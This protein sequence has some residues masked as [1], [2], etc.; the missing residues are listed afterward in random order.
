MEKIY[1]YSPIGFRNLFPNINIVNTDFTQPSRITFNF[2]KDTLRNNT[3]NIVFMN[4]HPE[5]IEYFAKHIL[6][7][8]T[9][10][11]IIIAA[12]CDT[13]FPDDSNG[14]STHERIQR[15]DNY[16][17]I[18]NN[19]FFK[20]W[21]TVNKIIPDDEKFTSIPY[22]LD[23]WYLEYHSSWGCSTRTAKIQDDILCNI[24]NNSLHFNKRIPKIYANW[25]LH[26]TDSRHGNY[27]THLQSIIPN[28][29]IHYDSNRSRDSCWE[30]CS[31]YAFVISP[32][33]NG[34]DCIR[35]WESLCLGCIVIVKTS[36]LDN[37]YGDLPVLIVNEWNDINAELL[38]K[39]IQ[40][41]SHRSFNMEKLTMDYWINKINHYIN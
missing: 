7:H 26:K 9:Y 4:A 25:H 35:T 30:E 40:E 23:Y 32:H 34:I 5:S 22:G 27:R 16:H 6:Q 41:F 24:T 38:D 3:T 14:W 36:A 29:I 21:F 37:L 33:G 20:H 15:G 12:F 8:I 19:I 2:D 28:D 39:I 18:I 17:E 1:Y 10:D 13:T 31:K 11:F